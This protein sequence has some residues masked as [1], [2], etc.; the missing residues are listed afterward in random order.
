[1]ILKLVK[2]I[3]CQSHRSLVIC[4]KNQWTQKQRICTLQTK[5]HLIWRSNQI[6]KLKWKLKPKSIQPLELNAWIYLI[7]KTIDPLCLQMIWQL[8]IIY[9]LT[10]N[11]IDSLWYS[12][13][14]YI[15][16]HNF[17]PDFQQFSV[18]SLK[19][20]AYFGMM[21]MNAYYWYYWKFRTK[22][23][24]ICGTAGNL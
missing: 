1:M 12:I 24:R 18:I 8:I 10:L 16:M 2:E 11:S 4:T 15:W 5:I 7:S 22:F 19:L 3:L 21:V 14:I 6:G 13:Y 20:N 23:N 17:L 9:L